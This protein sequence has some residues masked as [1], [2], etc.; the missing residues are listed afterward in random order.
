MA[1]FT[2]LTAS[3]VVHPMGSFRKQGRDNPSALPHE[4]VFAGN[5]RN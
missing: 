2:P 4:P 1:V 3:A 5:D